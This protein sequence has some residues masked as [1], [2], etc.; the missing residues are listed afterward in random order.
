[1]AE[2]Q[3]ISGNQSNSITEVSAETREDDNQKRRNG[4]NQNDSKNQSPA[5]IVQ[6]ASEDL[7]READLVGM[8]DVLES[9]V[10]SQYYF[11][12]ML[13]YNNDSLLNYF[14]LIA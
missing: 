2:K 10:V 12:F 1:M 6:Q 3:N 5:I 8:E 9:L 4:K 14:R 11:I 7:P 13:E